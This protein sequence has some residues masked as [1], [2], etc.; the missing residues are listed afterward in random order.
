MKKGVKMKERK[1]AEKKYEG[2]EEGTE[3]RKGGRVRRT[4]KI[5]KKKNVNKK[6]VRKKDVEKRC[7]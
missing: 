7:E 5:K 6:G 3:F 1:E 2:N 4:K